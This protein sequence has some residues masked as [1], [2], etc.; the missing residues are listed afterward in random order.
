MNPKE[1]YGFSPINNT[2]ADIMCVEYCKANADK[3]SDC[4][5]VWAYHYDY[6]KEN[7]IYSGRCTRCMARTRDF[8]IA[9]TRNQ[10][11]MCLIPTANRLS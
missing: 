10:L 8:R 4:K 11:I 2:E 5:F 9:H 6:S 3:P 7:P 1:L